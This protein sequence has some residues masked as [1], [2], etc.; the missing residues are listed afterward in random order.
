VLTLE[1]K[2][3]S[4]SFSLQCNVIVGNAVEGNLTFTCVGAMLLEYTCAGAKKKVF[5]HNAMLLL[6]MRLC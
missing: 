5:F 3:P 4:A 1:G 6:V 2:L